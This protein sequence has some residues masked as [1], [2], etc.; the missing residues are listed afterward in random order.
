MI[1]AGLAVALASDFN[2]G[3]APSGNMRFVASLASIKMKFLLSMKQKQI[4]KK[5]HC[6]KKCVVVKSVLS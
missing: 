2:P 1:D 5:R 3:T 6:L 4:L